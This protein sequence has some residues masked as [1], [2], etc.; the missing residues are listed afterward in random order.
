[1]E[2]KNKTDK[3]TLLQRALLV[4][5][6]LLGGIVLF[7][8]LQLVVSL[9]IVLF[10]GF[11]GNDADKISE[12]LSNSSSVQFAYSALAAVTLSASIYFLLR[13]RK[14]NPYKFLRLSK[15]PKSGHVGEVVILYGIYFLVLIATT[16]FVS[17][18]SDIN[19]DQTQD[20]GAISREGWG[21]ALTFVSLVILAPVV[22][23]VLFRGLLFRSLKHFGGRI[24]AYILVSLLFGAAHLEFDNLNYIAAIDTLIFSG[25]L[26]FIYEKH[27]SLYSPIM[28]HA[29]KNCIAF[30]ALF[31]II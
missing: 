12:L 1:M 17:V 22:E 3:S 28:L 26:I 23:E 19:V 2:L 25:F 8:G 15:P 18:T 16:V 20:L 27:A 10:L 30:I 13:W 11:A 4:L 9:V 6:T 5:A 24:A 7:Y 31:V 14:L 21:L 29:L